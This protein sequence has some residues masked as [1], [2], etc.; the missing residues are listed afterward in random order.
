MEDGEG[1]R[2][3]ILLDNDGTSADTL[4]VQGCQGNRRFLVNKVLLGRHKEP[5]AGTTNVTDAFKDGTLA[6]DLPPGS[7]EQHKVFTLNMIAPT[8]AEGVTYRCEMTISSQGD[9]A[10]TDTVVATITTY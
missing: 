6:F 3:W 4:L 1:V 2:F 10:R 7:E 8:P 9:P 5:E